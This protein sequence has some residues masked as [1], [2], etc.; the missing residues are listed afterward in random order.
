MANVIT[1]QEAVSLIK[2]GTNIGIG[3]FATFGAADTL[4]REIARSYA[5]QGTPKGLHIVAPAC[6]GD[7]QENG[8]GMSAMQANGLIASLVTSH[9]GQV[10]ALGRAVADNLFPTFFL[11]LGVFGHIFRAM[12]GKKPPILTHVGKYTF[13][14]PRVEACKANQAAIDSGREVVSLV[15]LEGQEYLCYRHLPMDICI[16]RGS[17]ADEDG[18]ISMVNEAIPAEQMEMAAAVHNNGGTVIVQVEQIVARHT[19]PP[20]SVWINKKLVNYVVV[21]KPGE[22]PHTY[23]CPEFRPEI[24]GQCRVP[25]GAIAPMELGVRKVVARRGAMELV[26]NALVNLGLGISDGVSIVASEEGVSDEIT[27]TIETGVFGGVPLGGLSTGVG[28]NSD[29]TYRTADTFDLYDGGVLDMAFLSS[30]EIDPTG[31]VNVTKFGGHTAGPGGFI[32][33][34]Q[35]VPKM[36][37]MG[38]FTAGKQ[39]VAVENG[40]LVIRKDGERIKFKQQVEQISFSGRYALETG[41]EVLYITERAVFRLTPDGLLLTEIAPGV[42]LEKDILGKMEFRPLI[43]PDLKTMDL[44]IF[45]PE[46]MGLILKGAEH[47]AV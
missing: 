37:F 19:L 12:A 10:P 27:L 39:D 23:E 13:C 47:D 46:K 1:A 21:A 14:D 41:Q 34:S 6:P 33:I 29:A 8:W 16:L 30:A 17:V 42:D 3:G 28:V 20:R 4:L 2:D 5:E 38:I 7:H 22:H 26:S 45:Q 43:S 18:N 11:P 35:N 36:C 31:N 32:N 25:T 9:V 44:R 40:K 15:E 24:V